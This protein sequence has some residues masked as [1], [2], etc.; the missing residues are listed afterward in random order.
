M[1]HASQESTIAWL[2][3]VMAAYPSEYQ[4]LLEQFP[5]G[6]AQRPNAEGVLADFQ[7]LWLSVV[8]GVP[9][10]Q[11]VRSRTADLLMQTSRNVHKRKSSHRKGSIRTRSNPGDVPLPRG[12][13]PKLNMPLLGRVSSLIEDANACGGLDHRGLR[14]RIIKQLHHEFPDAIDREIDTAVTRHLRFARQRQI[15]RH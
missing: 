6:K 9:L 5:K 15:P 10:P 8:T 13:K 14:S 12:V 1:T 4:Q 3:A 2:L 11:E 7:Y